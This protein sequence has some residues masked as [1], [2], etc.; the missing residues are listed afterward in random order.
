MKM[1]LL[2]GASRPRS[3]RVGCPKPGTKS[4]VPKPG[5]K[6]APGAP[7]RWRVSPLMCGEYA[8]ERGLSLRAPSWLLSMP[9]RKEPTA[10]G[11]ACAARWTGC[12]QH[13]GGGL[14]SHHCPRGPGPPLP[15]Q[16]FDHDRRTLGTRRLAHPTRGQ[17]GGHGI[18]R[19]LLAALLVALL[20]ALLAA[21]VSDPGSHPIRHGRHCPAHQGRPRTQDRCARPL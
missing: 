9:W 1:A 16:L 2:G 8:D 3:Q 5:T 13:D 11:T 20:V 10:A 15:R 19:H 21:S 12:A 7:R 6:A 17:S 14:Y 4:P 18:H